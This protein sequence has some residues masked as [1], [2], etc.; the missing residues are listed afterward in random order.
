M[1]H[2][3][4]SHT[5]NLVE[6]C[7]FMCYLFVFQNAFNECQLRVASGMYSGYIP[8]T[9]LYLFIFKI[10]IKQK[11]P[12]AVWSMHSMSASCVWQVECTVG[13]YPPLDFT[14]LFSK[15]ELNRRSPLPSGHKLM[16]SES[17][18]IIM[19]GF[20][21]IKNPPQIGLRKKWNLLPSIMDQSLGRPC[22]RPGAIPVCRQYLVLFSLIS[23]SFSGSLSVCSDRSNTGSTSF[24]AS[25]LEER[26]T[27]ADKSQN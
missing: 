10:R 1:M 14:Y 3:N 26:E 27:C 12:V 21:M 8:S 6:V 7:M 25:S 9:G 15:F 24:S 4:P 5:I 17:T 2:Y 11:K 22:F 23:A 18:E 20:Q 19:T 13:T 16:I